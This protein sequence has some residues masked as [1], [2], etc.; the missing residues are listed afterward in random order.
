M[1][2]KEQKTVD[3]LYEMILNMKSKNIA[4][5]TKLNQIILELNTKVDNKHIPIQ[6]EK[7]IL[8]VLQTSLHKIIQESLSGYNSP[9]TKL[10]N[11]VVEENSR[12]LKQIIS[13]SFSYSIQLEEFKQAIRDGFSHKI[14]RH[15]INTNDSL[16]HKISNELKQDA[17]FKSKLTIAVENIINECMKN[18]E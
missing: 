18:R 13:E 9:L 12:Q 8:Q 1:N 11:S 5:M 16:F 7:D 10:I 3:Q 17:V 15:I 2:S 14:A 6:L 4:L